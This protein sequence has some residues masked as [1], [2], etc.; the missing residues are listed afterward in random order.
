MA[1]AKPAFSE[2][3]L[4][5]NALNEAMRAVAP[6]GIS[7][8]C[9]VIRDGDDN[10]LLADENATLPARN[11]VRRRAS[12]AARI[13]ARELLK[14]YGKDDFAILRGASGEP[15]WPSGIVG[16]LA[17]DDDMAVA[18][19]ASSAVFLSVGIDVEPAIALPEDIAALVKQPGDRLPEGTADTDRILFCA[20]EAVYKAVY[21]LDRVILNYDDIIVDLQQGHARTTTDRNVR[22]VFCSAPKIIVLAYL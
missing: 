5:E 4:L 2:I 13:A 8:A 3:S 12:G 14:T 11:P 17:H 7:T 16:S 18:A 9:R 10:R 1:E 21:P 19:V 15:I 22:V 20:K 6:R